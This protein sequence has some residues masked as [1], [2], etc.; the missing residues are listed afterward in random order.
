MIEKFSVNISDAQI[1]DLHE[2]LAKTRWVEP[3]ENV[4]WTEGTPTKELQNLVQYWL[5][6][7]NWREHEARL[8]SL[9]QYKMIMENGESIHFIWK[10]GEGKSS[11]PLLISHGWPGSIVEMLQILPLLTDPEKHGGSSEDAFDVV[12]P[13]LPGYGFSS[14]PRV[15]GT[16]PPEIARA[17][18]KLM[19]ELGYHEFFAQGGD[20]GAYVVSSLAHQFPDNVRAIHLNYVPSPL[21]QISSIS[22]EEAEFKGIKD[23]WL[24][25]EGGY[26]HIHATKPLS[27]ASGLNDSPAG[28]AAWIYEKFHT[29]TDRK[30]AAKTLSLDDILTNIS[31]YWFTGTIYSSI[32]LYLEARKLQD[33]PGSSEY[34]IKPATGVSVFPGELPLPPRSWVKNKYNLVYWNEVSKGGHFAAM[35]QPELLAEELRHFFAQKG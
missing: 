29:W 16:G 11:R 35:E 1:A 24:S 6:E 18:A 5:T 31:I 9:P 25:K 13:S 28:L 20:W 32:R 30:N 12:L 10:K 2:R 27:I 15:Q 4:S 34:I 21:A 3:I 22:A 33:I 8:N 19:N 7:Y 23:D 26:S 17:Y 14:Q